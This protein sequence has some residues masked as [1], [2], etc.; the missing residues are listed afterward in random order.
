MYWSRLT[1]RGAMIGGWLGL[2][3]AVI[4][5]ILGPTIWVQILGHEKPI[6]PYEYPALFS[7]F[8]AFVGTGCSRSPIARWP[9]SRSGNASE[10]S[11]SVRKPG[12]A[13]LRA[14][15]INRIISEKQTHLIKGPSRPFL[16]LFIGE[17]G[18][19]SAAALLRFTHS[20]SP[21]LM[22]RAFG[23]FDAR[24]CPTLAWGDP[25]L[26]SALRRFTSEF[27][28]GSGGTTALLPPCKFC[29]IPTAS[30][31]CRH[32]NQS[33]NFAENLSKTPSVL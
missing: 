15:R 29:F 12:W 27:G 31:S 4:L 26:P 19:S 17:A 8:V 21:E 1:T 22:F 9:G 18:E 28:M 25:T 11:L 14:A 16:W 20:K 32:Q 23:W 33:R 13:S 30:L 3:T 6:Y 2:L 7:M 10:L 5:M 24:Q